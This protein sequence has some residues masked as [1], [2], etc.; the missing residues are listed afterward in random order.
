MPDITFVSNGGKVITV[1]PNSNL[2]RSSLREK[3]GIPFKCGGGVCGTCRCH[4]DEGLDNTDEVKAKERN[5]L[6]AEEIAAGW[7]MACQTF[8]NGDIKV[9]W[10]P[11]RA[12]PPVSAAAGPRPFVLVHGAWHG[13]WCW[14]KLK[15]LLQARGHEVYTPT[16]TGLG[17]RAHLN[18]PA[19]DLDTHVQDIVALLE[20]EDLERVV[21]VGH[22]YAGMVITG[23]L[24]RMPQRI[25][26]VVYLDA[27]L[28][29]DGKC[30]N[31]YSI[32]A[33]G[34]PEKV[35]ELGE[36][37]RLPFKGTLSLE[38]LGIEDPADLAWMLPRMTDQPYRTF[39][40]PLR[41]AT[42]AAA[43]VQRSYVLSSDRAHYVEAAQRAQSQGFRLV[44]VPGAG[45]DV[46]VTRPKELADALL[47]LAQ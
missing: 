18:S 28:P 4:I 27:F 24:S 40:Q 30:L 3:G 20:T 21:L 43:A 8:V 1:P 11:K 14:K 35:R 6:S 15:P 7:R 42:P 36:G 9:S 39:T 29:E 46:M 25:S 31:D 2:L 5:H 17:D 22:S 32:G 12:K 38:V 34:Y 41:F 13:G 45:H 23:V 16:L 19:V 37:W 44:N 26:Q 10:E 33:P 47:N